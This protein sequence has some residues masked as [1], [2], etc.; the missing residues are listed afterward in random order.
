LV[1]RYLQAD[2][3]ND[4]DNRNIG[5]LNALLM[6]FA[7][8]AALFAAMPQTPRD[9][10]IRQAN[11]ALALCWYY[12]HR[13]HGRERGD[14]RRIDRSVGLHMGPTLQSDQER[15]PSRLAGHVLGPTFGEKDSDEHEHS[16]VGS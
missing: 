15:S 2:L 11:V 1:V 3:T 13:E 7:L 16:R 5:S 10:M 14:A 8:P 12:A 9:A 6:N 4:I